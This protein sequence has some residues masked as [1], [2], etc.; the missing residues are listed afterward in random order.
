VQGEP[1][2]VLVVGGAGY[3]GNVL[4]RRLLDAGYL[5]RVLDRLVFNHGEA[6][7]PLLEHPRFSFIYGDLRDREMLDRALEGVTDVA[8]L[9]GLVGD[10]ITKSY[11]RLSAAVNLEGCSALI[12]ALDGRGI[13]RLV[14]TSTCSNYGLRKTDELAT[15][16]SE[17]APVSLYAEHKVE[18]EQLLLAAADGVDYAPTVLR[19]ST[20][21]G[22]SPRMRFD[23]T[24]AEFTL[25]MAASE[26]LVVYD[27]DTWR[28]Y[29]HVADIS[30]AVMAVLDAPR[31]LVSGEVFNT[32]HSDE[33]YTKR[34]VVDVVQECLG[35]T[36]DV[37]YMEGGVDPRNYRVSFDKI[38]STLGY[39]PDYR[40]PDFVASL[41]AAVRMGA[42]GDHDE[43]AGFFTNRQI[44]RRYLA[45]SGVAEG[46]ADG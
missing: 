1:R 33:N 40:V 37:S 15:E 42:Y 13:D 27:P 12:T 5:V 16:E 14:F 20:A 35:G 38:A 45:E 41:I 24:I 19:I 44:A 46:D 18:I 32:G 17:L 7:A 21:Y 11:P 8:L 28:P 30:K 6:I 4:V 36:G 26:K 2:N 43:R 10:P 29:C 31:D 25:T 34:M 39:E 9:G 3:V 23:L 22:L